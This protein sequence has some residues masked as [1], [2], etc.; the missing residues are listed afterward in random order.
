MQ[1]K[2][3][4]S[5]SASFYNMR[6]G[7]NWDDSVLT[8]GRYLFFLPSIVSVNFSLF[9]SL[10][11]CI[12]QAL[13]SLFVLWF[14]CCT[15]AVLSLSPFFPSSDSWIAIQSK[16]LAMEDDVWVAL[17]YN[18]P[19]VVLRSVYFSDCLSVSCSWNLSCSRFWTVFVLHPPPGVRL[20]AIYSLVSRSSWD[21]L[22]ESP[23]P[24]SLIKLITGNLINCSLQLTLRR[25]VDTRRLK[26]IV[27]SN[28]RSETWI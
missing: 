22:H 20:K 2:R 26:S 24:S 6:N 12:I 17:S 16:T 8:F 25:G 28:T 23:F 13:L 14:S 18:F 15:L 1:E 27:A 19:F 3:E 7:S 10:S 4:E 11:S 21:S 9:H 5:F